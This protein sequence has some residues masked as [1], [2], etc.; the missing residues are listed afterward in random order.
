MTNLIQH[1]V[2]QGMTTFDHADIY[3]DYSCEMLFGQAAANTTIARD[4][5]Q[6]V[7][8]CGI[9]LISAKKPAHT[10]KHYDTSREHIMASVENSL[11]ALRT[12][13]L[14]LLLIH[15]PDPLMDP[16]E[17]ATVFESLRK[18]GKVRHFGV[19]N[20]SASQ[21]D[22]LQRFCNFPLVTNQIELSLFKP[23]SFF[24]GTVDA[25]VRA[26]ASPMAWSPLGGGK[27]FGDQTHA[28][29]DLC[30][31]Y[32]AT[33]T[34][35]LLAWL[36]KHPAGVF[37]VI[38]TTQSSRIGEAALAVNIRLDREDWFRMLKHSTGKD[39]A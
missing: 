17:V 32:N 5:L 18:Q 10:I 15:R 33:E 24:D 14:D 35:L 23:Q 39:V 7:S 36:M 13:Y 8:K 38:G 16:H 31:K 19:S 21:F 6:L 4:Q 12:D 27:F 1:S 22:L 30:R 9:K 11:R 37:P 28:L 26:N 29:H 20:F 25:L 3:G 2:E 34:Q